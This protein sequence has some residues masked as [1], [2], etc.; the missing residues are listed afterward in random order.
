MPRYFFDSDDGDLHVIDDEGQ[1]AL[2]AAAARDLALS[3]L[4]HMARDKLPDGDRR[5]FQV[6]VRDERGDV[7]YTA[8]LT[9]RGEWKKPAQLRQAS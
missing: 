8:D 7:I 4:P 6:R 2:D 3:L 1:E 9:L 5:N